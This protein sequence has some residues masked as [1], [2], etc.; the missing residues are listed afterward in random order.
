MISQ[1]LVNTGL[2]NGL[3]LSLAE[4]MLTDPHWSFVAFMRKKYPQ[5]TLNSLVQNQI[6]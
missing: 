6:W 1:N 2:G 5:K 3:V 4:S